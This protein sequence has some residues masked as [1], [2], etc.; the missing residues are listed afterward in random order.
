MVL[1]DLFHNQGRRQPIGKGFVQGYYVD[2]SSGDDNNE[3]R[4]PN[5]PW[6]TIAKVN[7]ATFLPGDQI[8]F[9]KGEEWREQLRPP[10]SGTPGNPITFGA[11][12]AGNNPILN[13][14]DI[15]ETWSDETGNVWSASFT[16]DFTES[17]IVERVWFDGTLGTEEPGGTGDLNA[18][19]EWY[20]ND[21]T[22]TLYVYSTGDPDDDYTSPGIEAVSRNFGF[23]VYPG[24]GNHFVGITIDGIDCKKAYYGIKYTAAGGGTNTGGVVKNMALSDCHHG[25]QQA[26]PATVAL[27]NVDSFDN[28][29]YGYYMAEV[30]EFT[31]DGCTAYDN[32]GWGFHVWNSGS[33]TFKNSLAYGNGRSGFV[34]GDL[35]DD[36][37]VNVEYCIAY[38]NFWFGFQID[39]NGASY[40]GNNDINLYNCV[41]YGHVDN[42]AGFGMEANESADTTITIKNCISLENIAS[43]NETGDLHDNNDNVATLVLDN[44]L[45]YRTGGTTMITF[46]GSTYTQAQFAAYQA[47]EAPQDANSLSADPLFV[48]PGAADF[49]LQSG[50]PCR[51]EGTDVGLTEDYDGVSV[52][53]ETNPAIGAYEYV[54]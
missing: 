22:D 33:G 35:A 43:S 37:N 21:A 7:A 44:N 31:V 20:Y 40:N 24:T 18:E 4:S 6:Q 23:Y 39:N 42:F 36:A 1:L 13:G 45:Y 50:S 8:L 51:D 16:P 15:V 17:N 9:K 53:Q 48:N 54:V 19:N 27:S 28:G 25:Y 52:P 41:A 12:G 26:G 11:Y 49:H 3:G 34:I 32:V 29:S 2:A 30:G 14:S 46:G 47:A 38:D 5:K 10:T